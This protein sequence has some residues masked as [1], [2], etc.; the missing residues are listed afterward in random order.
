MRT[1]NE[2]RRQTNVRSH[3]GEKDIHIAL[4]QRQCTVCATKV[5]ERDV[6]VVECQPDLVV[7]QR[8]L[9]GLCPNDMLTAVA[10]GIKFWDDQL[11]LRYRTELEKAFTAAE[12]NSEMYKRKLQVG[13]KSRRERCGQ[14]RCKTYT[15]L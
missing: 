12:R 10:H 11:E 4:E 1:Q 5:V 15:N 6:Q 14:E 2:P 13:L 8:K 7:L 3:A 9:A